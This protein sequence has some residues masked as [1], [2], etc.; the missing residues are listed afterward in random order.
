MNRLRFTEV[1]DDEIRRT[2]RLHHPLAI[3]MAD[4]DDLKQ[5]NDR[6]GHAAGDRALL[7]LAHV[8]RSRIRAI[9]TV[10]RLGGDEFALLLPETTGAQAGE[11][12]E[13]IRS[14][15]AAQRIDLPV[16]GTQSH[17]TVSAGVASWTP[18][19]DSA[20]AFL[21]RADRALYEA[22]Q[23]GRNRVVLSS[24]A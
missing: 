16:T 23:A 9:D 1:L 20:A 17:V 8:C 5:V 14:M 7:C 6:Y 15:M 11:I 19:Q 13:R 21:D 4:L 12:L 10:A 3:A 18:A 24:G 2:Q 22:K